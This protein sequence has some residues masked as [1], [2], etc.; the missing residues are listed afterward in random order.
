[1]PA[2]TGSA[3]WHCPGCFA[4]LFCNRGWIWE[5]RKVSWIK[6][7]F[8]VLGSGDITSDLYQGKEHLLILRAKLETTELFGVTLKSLFPTKGIAEFL[9]ELIEP[10]SGS[11]SPLLLPQTTTVVLVVIQTLHNCDRF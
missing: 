9:K 4:G 1:M 10:D 11:Q 6:T 5:G 3:Y 7:L 8:P 2:F